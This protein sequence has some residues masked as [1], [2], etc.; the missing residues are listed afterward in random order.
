MYTL[1]STKYGL[2]EVLPDS[3]VTAE[4]GGELVLRLFVLNADSQK[5]TSA[6][7]SLLAVADKL[8]LKKVVTVL[9]G[10]P[11]ANIKAVSAT[12]ESDVILKVTVTGSQI[13]A[14]AKAIISL[15]DS[16]IKPEAVKQGTKAASRKQGTGL[17]SGLVK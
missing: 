7:T 13:I 14:R 10:K 4:A 16:D 2:F 6:A 5:A 15:R 11:K 9:V 12:A 8:A 17:V 3:P 1:S